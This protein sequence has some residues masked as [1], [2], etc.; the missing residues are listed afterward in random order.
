[1]QGS[2]RL[3]DGPL[4]KAGLFQCADGD[5][6]LIAI[7]HLIV[8]GVSWRILLEDIVSGYRQAENGQVVQLPQKTDSFQ[9]WAK[10]LSEYAQSETIKQEQEYWTKI[11]QTEVKPLPTDFH[12]TQTTAKDSETAA[13]E[14]TKEETELLLKQANRAY[15]TEINDLLL[16]S[17]GLSI[18]HWSGLEHIPIHLEGHGREQIFQDMDISRTVGWFTSLYPVVLHAQ[19]GKEISDY[20]KMTKEGL[21][22]IPDK[23]IGYGIARYLSGG[24]PS[25]LNPEISFNYLGQFDQDLQQHRVQLSSYSCGSDSSGNQAR[26]YVLN[27]NGMITDGRLTLT[28]SYSSKQYARETIKRLAETIQSCLRTIIT[29]CVQKE[30]SELTPSDILLKGM[31]IDELDQLLIQLPHAGE[32]ENV[33][34]L[35]PMQKGML[36]HSLLDEDSH[37]YFEQASFDLQGELKI[38]WF[39]ASLERLFE[40]YAVLRTRFYSGWNDT[41]LQIVYKTQKPQ[42]HFADL[43]DKEEYHRE[44]EIAAYQR[45]DKEKG[46]DLARGPLM[47]IAIFRMEDRK[48]HLIWSFHHIVM[49]G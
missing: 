38:D 21:R 43:R 34:P 1:I 49:D 12:E 39:K 46:F 31:S 36:F 27:I 9:L 37:S 48:Y 28:I 47:R 13:V 4:M 45:E 32:I 42:I 41:P 7:H 22:Q 40:K 23:G 25:K 35:T 10:R 5:H 2:M 16:T 15:N 24:M 6:L 30:Q 17:L 8:D 33:Y 19:P 11:E 26:P 3:S 20:I 29:H 14:W 44:D 18:S